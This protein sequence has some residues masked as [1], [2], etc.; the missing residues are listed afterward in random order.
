MV[1]E[2]LTVVRAA[3]GYILS[4]EFG[5]VHRLVRGPTHLSVENVPIE[6]LRKCLWHGEGAL[7][8]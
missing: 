3:S 5:E 6:H 4:S 7:A 1:L 2:N 8:G